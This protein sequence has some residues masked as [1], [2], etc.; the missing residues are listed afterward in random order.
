MASE[1]LISWRAKEAQW[2]SLSYVVV[3]LQAVLR[4]K[5]KERQP[6]MTSKS[7]I[8]MMMMLMIITIIRLAE[9][10][11]HFISQLW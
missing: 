6:S 2:L 10:R 11:A 9:S 3:S 4:P 1:K 8:M 7:S 5:R